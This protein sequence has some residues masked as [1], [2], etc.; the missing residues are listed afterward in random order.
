MELHAALTATFRAMGQDM[1]DMAIMLIAA[2]LENEPKEGVMVAL[3]RC[4]KELRRITLADILD[5]IP[6]GHPG[7]EEAWSIVAKALTDERV[8]VV[9]TDQISEAFGRA[10]D[11]NDD[12]VAARMTFKEVYTRLVAEARDCG[13][14]IKWW[15]SLGYD[16]ANREPVLQEAVRKGRLTQPHVA[17]LLPYSQPPA[18]AVQALIENKD[19]K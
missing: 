7:V 3:N 18:E 12:P 2:D 5:R 11:L 15:P 19:R 6:G 17:G 14:P 13:K 8:T 9:M 1:P 16:A 4:R 10:L